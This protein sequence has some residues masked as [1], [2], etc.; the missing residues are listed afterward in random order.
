[1]PLIPNRSPGGRKRALSDA[2]NPNPNN[3]LAPGGNNYVPMN[4]YNSPQFVPMPMSPAPGGYAAAPYPYPMG[5]PSPQFYPAELV[6][7]PAACTFHRTKDS[8]TESPDTNRAYLQPTVVDPRV[9][10]I[11]VLLSPPTP[12]V[13]HHVSALPHHAEGYFSE[14]V[15]YC[16]QIL[17]DVRYK[18]DKVYIESHGHPSQMSDDI[19]E[20][21]A[22]N[23]PVPK[24]RLIC[25]DLPWKISV[26][27]TKGV[28]LHNV[29]TAVYEELQQPLTEGEWWIAADEERDRCMD[30]YKA[31]CT[32]EAG[33]KR[34]LKDGVKRVDWLAKKTMLVSITRTP[35]DEA[36]IKARIPDPKAQGE[37]W[38]LVMGEA[39]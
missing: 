24:M 4:Y 9:T 8:F 36:F 15:W 17:Y 27:N 2:R 13:G 22:T 3:Y 29:L 28:T 18:P 7:N 20:Q 11:H 5:W 25:R 6:P 21:P 16:L 26:S 14:H 12:G 32:E 23:P 34:D 30:A 39:Q 35:Y 37:T 19:A 10:Q 33:F 1:M 31:N 38:V